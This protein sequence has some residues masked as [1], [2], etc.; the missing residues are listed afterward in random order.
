MLRSENIPHIMKYMGGKREMLGAIADAIRQMEMPIVS[1]CD[2]FAGTSIVSFLMADECDVVSNDVQS[3][4]SLIAKAYFG[5]Y[6]NITNVDEFADN[7][8][9]EAQKIVEEVE[10]RYPTLCFVYEEEVSFDKM[11][12][13]ELA[14][15]ALIDKDFSEGFSLFKK[16]YSGTYWSYEQC[17]WI[18]AIRAISERYGDEPAYNAIIASL[19]YAMS[20]CAQ[21]TGHF[22][23]YRSLTPSNYRSVLMYRMKSIP[24][25][26]RKKLVELLSVTN[27]PIRHKLRTT[28]LDCVDC[29]ATLLPGTLV[30]A[31]PPYSA[32]HYSRFYHV[33]ETLVR[34]DNPKLE[35]KGRYRGNRY[36]SPFDQKSNVVRA[37]VSLFDAI[38][39]QGCHLLLSYSDNAMLAQDELISLAQQHLG[40]NY[41]MNVFSKDYQ[42]MKMGRSDKA[43]MDVHELIFSFKLLKK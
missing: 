28:T 5:D 38:R 21:S 9:K 16:C 32:V 36:Q 43:R 22:A 27:I 1:F 8:L 24:V 33:I 25:L 26:F 34:Y 40:I 2:L 6:S 39:V 15:L 42:H 23:Q 29:I 10:R 13:M 30:Y 19:I 17:V 37:F 4:S 18:D 41:S 14:Q 3:Y 12:V 7:V 31:D 11:E 20:Y 35:H